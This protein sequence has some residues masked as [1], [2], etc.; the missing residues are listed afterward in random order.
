MIG[1]QKNSFLPGKLLNSTIWRGDGGGSLDDA[2]EE[3][4]NGKQFTCL[5]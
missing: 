1:K 4:K 3:G 2:S 5:Y